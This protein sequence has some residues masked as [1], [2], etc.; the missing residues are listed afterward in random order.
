MTSNRALRLLQFVVLICLEATFIH[1]FG[2]L[3]TSTSPSPGARW[4]VL[5][6]VAAAG[7]G[8]TIWLEP[9]NDDVPHIKRTTSVVAA[10]VIWWGTMAQSGAISPAGALATVRRLFNLDDP[11]FFNTYLALATSLWAWWRGGAAV[12]HGHAEVVQLLRRAVIALLV[13]LGLLALGDIDPVLDAY[14]GTI[15]VNLISEIIAFLGLGFVALSLTRITEYPGQA[16]GRSAWRWLRSGIVSTFGVIAI[17][18]AAL[19]VFSRPAGLLLRFIARWVVF[20]VITLLAPLIAL[21]LAIA[22]FIRQRLPDPQFDPLVI[23]TATALPDD[24]ASNAQR[25]QLSD[26][27][28]AIPVIVLLV[29]PI[30]VL[31]LLIYLRYRRRPRLEI[32]GDEQRQSIFSWSDLRADIGSMLGGLWPQRDGGGLS[33][34]L[35]RLIGQDPATRVRR[36]YIQLLL[37]GETVGHQRLP[38]QTPHE[39]MPDLQTATADKQAVATL[40]ESYE[41]ARYAPESVDDTLA[42]RADMAWQRLN[43]IASS[44]KQG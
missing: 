25:I 4:W 29:I 37:R 8:A 9:L 36:R 40:T 14:P 6:V 27:L 3:L 35:R 24:M 1:L 42:Q 31:L 38:E 43:D 34:A 19:A 2:M 32:A 39:F 41:Q 44:D 26:T 20:G 33:G 21:A 5:V 28:L 15:Y 7:A 12:D 13:V 10:L 17:G 30:A 16:S 22:E 18:V 11:R 23:P